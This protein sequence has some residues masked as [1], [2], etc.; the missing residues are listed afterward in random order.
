MNTV[1]EKAFIPVSILSILLSGI[2]WSVFSHAAPP[3]YQGVTAEGNYIGLEYHGFDIVDDDPVRMAMRQKGLENIFT[4]K[5]FRLAFPLESVSAI[6]SAK[7]LNDKITSLSAGISDSIFS[8]TWQQRKPFRLFNSD[9]KRFQL[10]GRLPSPANRPPVYND[11]GQPLAKPD[12]TT[13]II[14]RNE[15]FYKNSNCFFCHSGVSAGIVSAGQPN[16]HIDQPGYAAELTFLISFAKLLERHLTLLQLVSF[17]TIARARFN[18]KLL[19]LTYLFDDVKAESQPILSRALVRG[20]NMGPYIV[21]KKIARLKDPANSGLLTLR[22]DETSPLDYFF[23]VPELPT[24]ISNPWWIRKYK[25]TNYR[26]ADP[27]KYI[28]PHFA[29]N[30]TKQFPGVNEYHPQHVADISE[31]LVYA[32]NTTSP[33]YPDK[34]D[35]EKVKLGKQLFHSETTSRSGHRLDCFSCHGRYQKETDFDTPGGYTVYYD[36]LDPDRRLKNVGTDPEY[37]RLLLSFTPLDKKGGLL[38]QFFD[39]PELMPEAFLP[40]KAGY[41]A[42]PLDGVW[43][44]APYFHNGSVPT[45]YHVLKADERPAIWSRTNTDPFAYDLEKVGLLYQEKD[46]SPENYARWKAAAKDNPRSEEAREFRRWYNTSGMGRSNQGHDWFSAILDNDEIYAVVEF[47][48]SLSGP[49]MKNG[50]PK[51]KRYYQLEQ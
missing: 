34:L 11:E 29:F 35:A 12:L 1:V 47:L 17:N 25:S 32:D 48:K 51:P 18:N 23:Q 43:A 40:E 13:S 7:Q 30:F 16:A 45:L 8:A 26:Y 6:E 50:M 46:I 3:P 21:W 10:Y 38:A 36:D 4:G 37:A 41:I 24:V 44:S 2:I 15:G 49:T 39:D 28:V 14:K 20:D 31:I 22:P 33:A 27:T 42:P 9:V 19:E 5:G